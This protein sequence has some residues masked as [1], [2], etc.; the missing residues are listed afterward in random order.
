MK[1]LVVGGSGLVGSNVVELGRDAGMEVHATYRNTET[2]KTGFRLDKTDVEQTMAV[3]EEVN[4]DVVVDTAAFHAVDDCESER[5]RAWSVNAAGSRNVAAA[6]NSADA[7][8]IH[9]STDYVFPGNP[10]ETPYIESDPVRPPNYYA[11]TK[12]AAEQ[13]AKI[14]DTTTILRPSVIYGLSNANFVTWAL[15]ELDKRNELTIVDDQIS[16]PTY[17]PDLARACLTVA[18]DELTGLY[19]ATG[20]CSMSRYEFTTTL[21]D[22]CDYDSDLITPI[23]TEE[24]GQKAPRPTDSTLDST[25]LYDAIDYQFR[26]PEKAFETMK[27]ESGR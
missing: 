9:L 18:E 27:T 17:A 7:H 16:A 19:H 23:S 26:A 5:D 20:P 12:Y 22:V 24:F 8:L 3:V 25:R 14:A 4:P 10:E 13:A 1:L 11:E 2:E 6:A 21:A 15:E